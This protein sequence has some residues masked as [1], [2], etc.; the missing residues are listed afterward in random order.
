M[1]STP[2]SLLED[3]LRV[4]RVALGPESLECAAATFRAG[5]SH[6]RDVRSSPAGTRAGA[7]HRP[8]PPRRRSFSSGRDARGRRQPSAAP[9]SAATPRSTSL[10]RATTAKGV[11][12]LSLIR[13][14][15]TAAANARIDADNPPLPP[16]LL[17]LFCLMFR[18]ASSLF[19]STCLPLRASRD[20]SFDVAITFALSLFSTPLLFASFATSSSGPLP[21]RDRCQFPSSRPPLPLF[22][23]PHARR[24][25]VV[26]KAALMPVP[27]RRAFPR[28]V[29]RLP[30]DR[31]PRLCRPPAAGDRSPEEVPGS[32]PQARGQGHGWHA[33]PRGSRRRLR[34][35]SRRTGARPLGLLPEIE[36]Q[37]PPPPSRDEAHGRP[38]SEGVCWTKLGP[39]PETGTAAAGSQSTGITR[40]PVHLV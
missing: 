33:D 2:W 8:P 9:S 7:D 30:L 20:R 29:A 6:H 5:K 21:S 1:S 38:I 4:R 32:R 23:A 34:L 10:S 35:P 17:R 27:T 25:L 16:S 12:D 14:L 13:R 24:P 15:L 3:A 36:T 31:E 11:E 40:P 26:A 39:F 18:S 37:I 19:C 22:Q 28:S